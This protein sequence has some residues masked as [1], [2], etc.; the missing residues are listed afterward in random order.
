MT[1]SPLVILIALAAM[2]LADVALCHGFGVSFTHWGRVVPVTVAIAA[3]GAV[4]RWSGRS[5]RIANMALW[6][7]LW[8]SFSVVG[9]ILTYAAAT[10]AGPLR[11]AAYAAFDRSLGFDWTAWFDFVNR[12]GVLKVAL[13][14]IYM[15]LTAQILL[16]VF[17]FAYRGW[18]ERNS[19]L[20]LCVIVAL[21]MTTAV[22]ALFP[23]LGPCTGV[24]LFDDLYL[25]DLIGLRDGSLTS[26]DLPQMKGII[27][28]PSFHAVLAAL[29]TYAHR[30]WRGFAPVAALNTVMLATIPSEGGHYLVDVIAGL[31]IAGVA[32]LLVRM[33][34]PV[35]R[36]VMRPSPA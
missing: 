2:A 6:V 33:T 1:R 19:E 27:A 26:F 24:R 3:V 13:A 12:H 23:A 28:F 5:P 4:Y 34:Q 20:L 14:L 16:S 9:A 8:I 36:A 31:A 11:D 21:V 30:G 29:F 18:D 17:V 15:S 32:I 22:F 10:H 7:V 35:E 25:G